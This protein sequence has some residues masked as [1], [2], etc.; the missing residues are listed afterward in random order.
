MVYIVC[1][2]GVCV[3]CGAVCGGVFWGSLLSTV[4]SRFNGDSEEPVL[5]YEREA[6]SF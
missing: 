4:L 6:S 2:C 3:V 1:V 5:T